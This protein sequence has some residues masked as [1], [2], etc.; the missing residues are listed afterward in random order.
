MRMKNVVSF[1]RLILKARESLLPQLQ[2]PFERYLQTII[3][4]ERIKSR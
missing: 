2:T 4:T 3:P 1:Y